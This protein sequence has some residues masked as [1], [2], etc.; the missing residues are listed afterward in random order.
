MDTPSKITRDIEVWAQSFPIDLLERCFDGFQGLP[1]LS[2]RAD[3]HPH[4]TLATEVPVTI[5]RE[6]STPPHGLDEL[7]MLGPDLHQNKVGRAGPL[8]H[9]QPLEPGS[10]FGARGLYLIDIPVKMIDVVERRR[11]AGERERVHAVGRNYGAKPMLGLFR[12]GQQPQPQ[13][14]QTVGFGKRS[15]HD[16]VRDLANQIN[17][18][19][20]EEVEVGFIN[21]YRRMRRALQDLQDLPRWANAPVGL[22]GLAMAMILVRGVMASSRARRGKRKSSPGATIFAVPSVADAYTSY[23]A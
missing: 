20:P 17:H 11:Q 13:P 9:P 12:S 5:P 1:G 14:S 6:H 10:Q 2:A 21:Q 15:R 8:L 23:M 4:T 19:L 3:C 16:Q 7:G 22:L 18:R